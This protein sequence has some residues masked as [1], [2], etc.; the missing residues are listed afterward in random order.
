MISVKRRLALLSILGLVLIGEPHPLMAQTSETVSIGGVPAVLLRPAGNPRGS[1]VLLSGGDGQI[2]VGPDGS[3]AFGGNQLVRTRQAYA[4]QGYVVLVPEG[5]ASVPAAVNYMAQLKRPVA[6]VG[7]SRGTQR[8]ARGIAAG[9]RPDA[10]VLT[11]GFLSPQSGQGVNIHVMGVVGSPGRLPRT[12]VIHHR[13]DGCHF[14]SPEGVAPFLAW[15]Q[16]KAQVVWL[17]GGF[18][19]GDPCQARGY[20]GFAGLDDRVVSAVSQFVGG[21]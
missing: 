19:G 16:G 10:L 1:I 21:R 12:L 5:E 18:D 20:H 7:T 3:V 9:A 2:G 14:T 13:R 15:A 8:A 17:D 6:L 11:S 4:S